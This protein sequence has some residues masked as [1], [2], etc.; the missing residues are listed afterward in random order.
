MLV[1]CVGGGSNAMGLFYPFL[2]D[3]EVR[4][5]GVEAAGAGLRSG[6]HGAPLSAGMPGVLH[7]SLSYLIQDE[8]GQV[9][10]AHSI[11]AGLDYPGV[12]PEH[13][14]L[15][16]AGRAEYVAVTDEEALDALMLLTRL[17]GIIPA[18]ESAHAVAHAVR[19]AATLPREARLVIGLSGRG[20]KDVETVRAARAARSQ[21]G[22]PPGRAV[23]RIDAAFAGL[24]AR[25]ERALIPYFV[26]GDPSLEM[27]AR[28]IEEADAR[29]ADVIEVGL[30]FSDPLADGPTIQ[31]AAVRAL[32]RGTS[33]YRLLPVLAGVSG[34]IRAPLVLM[35]YLNPLHRYGLEKVAQD[36]AHA[37]VAGLI[38]PDCPVDESGPLRRR[39]ARQASTSSP[40][41]RRRAG[42]SASAGSRARAAG[43]STSSRCT[44]LTG[45]RTELPP[46]FVRMVRDLR[47]V[48]TKPIGVGFGISTPAQVAAVVHHADA[49][50][51]RQRNRAARREPGR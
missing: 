38:V 24:R 2:G 33:L 17:E 20:D 27:T 11:S 5:V 41:S 25:H 28:L 34:R 49:R 9:L 32:E 13:S 15:K 18:L 42:R 37:G 3:R 48:T 1:A 31:R 29:G 12:G 51:R 6:R 50:H 36:L 35:T 46:E 7:G 23:S 44:G 4:L 39:R 8:D 30:P 21:P 40:S 47:S 19:L 16:D 10:P 43:S 26:A 45:E 14:W 22:P